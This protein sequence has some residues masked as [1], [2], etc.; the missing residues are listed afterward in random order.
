M[1]GK[2]S[3]RQKPGVSVAGEAEV[4]SGAAGNEKVRRTELA[5]RRAA[6][7]EEIRASSPENWKACSEAASRRARRGPRQGYR[8]HRNLCVGNLCGGEDC[9]GVLFGISTR[10]QNAGAGAICSGEPLHRRANTR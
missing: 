10:R 4:P 2:L 3:T 6:R 1:G 8:F 7:G 9:T 5:A